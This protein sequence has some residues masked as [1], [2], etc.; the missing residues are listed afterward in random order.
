MKF[1][2]I[3]PQTEY[4]SDPSAIKD[5]AQTVEDLGYAHIGC[6][7]HVLGVN[8]D[9]PGGWQ[10]QYTYQ[11]AF[12]EPFTLFSFFAAVTQ[13]TLFT[14][15]VLILPQ[16][17]T[18][19]VA[20]QAATLD[21]LSEGRLRL[22]VGLGWNAVEY[23]C[24]NENFHNRG[25]RLE[26]QIE[27]L[28]L[29]W[30]EPLASFSG[31]WHTIPD[32]GINPLPVQRPIPIWF[33]GRAEPALKRAA[34]LGDGWVAPYRTPTEAMP[35]FE[36]FAQYLDEA[37]RSWE[38]YSVEVRLYYGPGDPDIWKK[39]VREWQVVGVDNISFNTMGAGFNS[40]YEHL[41]AIRQFAE[42][43]GLHE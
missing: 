43:M 21:V 32:A 1:G 39:L 16:R 4:G 19:L 7:D 18:A 37:D 38:K 15:G 2:V 41:A 8:P 20:K 26:E 6:F 24:L 35:N 13:R 34:R 30:T 40:P 31:R 23:T 14:T 33:G 10:G 42:E 12:Q 36:K 11:S 29:L 3:Y 27:V 22:G 28:R 5:F 17:Q 25:R 9:R